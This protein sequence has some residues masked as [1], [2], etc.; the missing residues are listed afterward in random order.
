MW[1]VL[2]LV[3]ALCAVVQATVSDEILDGIAWV[4][5]QQKERTKGDWSEKQ[6]KH[7]AIGA[8]QIQDIYRR[9]ANRLAKGFAFSPTDCFNYRASKAMSRLVLNYWSNYYEKRGQR[10]GWREYLSLHM[11][12]GAN[13]KPGIEGKKEEQ[14]RHSR[15]QY[16]L[17][18][19]KRINTKRATK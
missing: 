19:K 2:L 14:R 5:A 1:K 3:L 4:E 12:P 11:R 10:F 13:W 9:E 8:F 15:Y 6:Q 17:R 7:L 16:Y 18:H